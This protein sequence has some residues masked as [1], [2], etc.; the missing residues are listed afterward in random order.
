MVGAR[1]LTRALSWFLSLDPASV[2]LNWAE[3]E[4][5]QQGR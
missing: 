1:D 5:R 3:A 2:A 4:Q